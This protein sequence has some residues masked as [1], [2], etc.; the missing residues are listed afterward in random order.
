MYF[1]KEKVRGKW[2]NPEVLG[3]S[4]DIA[5]WT[6]KVGHQILPRFCYIRDFH[7]LYFHSTYDYTLIFASIPA[8]PKSTRPP[9]PASNLLREVH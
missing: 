5:H 2:R 4:G 8:T 9:I 1:V 6:S 3:G 7:M